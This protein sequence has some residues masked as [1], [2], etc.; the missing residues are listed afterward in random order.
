MSFLDADERRK[1]VFFSFVQ[2]ESAFISVQIFIA[3]RVYSSM[4]VYIKRA[5]QSVALTHSKRFTLRN[6]LPGFRGSRLP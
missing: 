2:R 1:R 4:N 3:E 5:T 6:P